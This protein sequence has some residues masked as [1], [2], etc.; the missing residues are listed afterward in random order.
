MLYL[1]N[2]VAPVER[3]SFD[4]NITHEE[5]FSLPRQEPLIDIGAYSLIPN[6]FHLILKARAEGGIT[7]FMRKLSTGYTMYFNV[8]RKRI[9]NLFVKPFR[10]KHIPDDR[11]FKQVVPYVLFNAI[12]LFEPEWK[13][14]KG[15]L[16]SIEKKLREYQYSSLNDFLGDSRPENVII[17]NVLKE[18]YPEPN[19]EEMLA[20]AQEFYREH[21]KTL[22]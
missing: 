21:A 17:A 12:E 14:G 4:R 22:V 18:F 16:R 7:K 2:D 15:N 19:L 3:S 1:C 6:H 9:G 20:N 5:I 11:Y 10:S 8:K 13:I